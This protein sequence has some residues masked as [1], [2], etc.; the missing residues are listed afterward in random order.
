MASKKR[1]PTLAERNQDIP[2]EQGMKH[3]MEAILPYRKR[4]HLETESRIQEF[5]I[6]RCRFYDEILQVMAGESWMG[7]ADATAFLRM[8]RRAGGVM[9]PHLEN[10]L[11]LYEPTNCSPVQAR[12]AVWLHL[13]MAVSKRGTLPFS[14]NLLLSCKSRP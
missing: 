6:Y 11:D 8:L 5:A 1:R 12:N 13:K 7:K 9:P 14:N 2:R 10:C 4:L 3:M